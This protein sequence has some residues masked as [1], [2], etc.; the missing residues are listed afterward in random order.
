MTGLSAN[1]NDLNYCVIIPTYNNALTLRNVITEVQKYTSDI[2]VVN[3]GSTDESQSVIESFSNINSIH[4]PKNRGKGKALRQGFQW[5]LD[6]GFEYV[7]SMDSDGQHFA[8]DLPVFF[9]QIEKH[10][11]TLIIGARNMEGTNVPGKSSFGNNFSNFWFHLETGI[12]LSDTQSGYRLYPIKAMKNIRLFTNRFE[13]EVEVIVKA[14]WHGIKVTNVP[15]NIH[16]DPPET[17]ITH[18]R[19][20]QDFTRISILNTYLVTLTLLYYLPLRFFRNFSLSKVREFII[21]HFFD[22]TE[23]VYIKA[24]SIGFGVF[25][26]IFPIWGYQ[27]IV[28]ITLSHFLKLNKA[29]FIVAAHIS[30]PPMIP[31]IVYASYRMG[32]MFVENPIDDLFSKDNFGLNSIH[33]HIAQYLYGSVFLALIAGLISVI[34]SYSLIWLIRLFK[35]H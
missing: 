14:A 12:K 22:R 6:R 27:L 28:G 20:F 21:K 24:L 7:I 9:E 1:E 11:D 16:Y 3:D 33:N 17:R 30:I 34:L 15:I 5:A 26:G 19:P 25:M 35:G 2:L 31:I 10:P 8:S 32:A 29:I 13:F 23:P 18:F 4:F